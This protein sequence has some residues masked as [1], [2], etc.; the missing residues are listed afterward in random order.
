MGRARAIRKYLLGR[1]LSA[2]GTFF[3]LATLLFILFRLVPGDPTL[4]VL[5]PALSPEVQAELRQRFGLDQPMAV[6]YALYLKNIV[7]AHF[8]NSFDRGVPVVGLLGERVTNTLVL[9]LPALIFAYALGIAGGAFI[10][11][12]RGSLLERSVT[13]LAIMFRAAPVFW[14][15]IVFIALFSIRLGLFPAGHMLTPGAGGGTGVGQY[16][17]LDF[18]HHVALPLI[19]MTLYYGCYPLLVMRTS[20]LEVLG[21][22][23]IDLCKAKGLSERA[24]VFKHA[25]RASLLPIATSVSLL[26]AYAVAG[27]VL[28]EA[29]FSWPGVGLLMVEAV[30]DS[31]YPVAQAA[32]LLIALLTVLGNLAAD[33]IYSF[34]DPRIRY[35]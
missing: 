5:S 11:W 31:D 22:D 23:F 34:I 26:A 9:M 4:T 33:L 24:V 29:V 28:V 18:L 2:A 12:K 20:M 21:D 19:V 15:C 30:L 17:S 32:F 8:G 35:S 10:A 16:L 7:T 27:S 13:L 3:V 14:L 6:Q 1:I 25:L